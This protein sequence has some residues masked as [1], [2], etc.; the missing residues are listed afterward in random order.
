MHRRS[1]REWMMVV[2]TCVLRLMVLVRLRGGFCGYAA[3]VKVVKPAV[4]ANKVKEMLSFCEWSV[5]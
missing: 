4:L 2:V 5:R 3:Q 1:M